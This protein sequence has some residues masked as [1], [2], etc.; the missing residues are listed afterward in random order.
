MSLEERFNI[1]NNNK[2]KDIKDFNVLAG[3]HFSL[4]RIILYVYIALKVS[5]L[6]F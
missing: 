2:G 6:K 1:L 3:A 4:H 5:I